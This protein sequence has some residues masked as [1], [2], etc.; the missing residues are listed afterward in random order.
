MPNNLLLCDT[1]V[2]IDFINGQSLLLP[3]LL[4]HQL[5]LFTNSIIEMELFQG[6]H[7]QREL[8][9]IEQKLNTFRRLEINQ[10]VLTLAT[11]WVRRYSLSHH[12]RL[13]DAVIAATAVLYDIQLLTYNTSDFR[14]LS[15]VQLFD[16]SGY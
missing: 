2:I 14:Y 15:N 13:A 7:D 4:D 6:A 5:I 16:Y 11:Q 10:D 3:T 9:K 1:C 8:R 12:L